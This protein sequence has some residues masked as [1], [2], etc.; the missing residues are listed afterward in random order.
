LVP[1]MVRKATGVAYGELAPPKPTRTLSL[2]WRKGAV[3]SPAA[4]AMKKVVVETLG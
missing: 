1:S 4:E 3:L 2:A